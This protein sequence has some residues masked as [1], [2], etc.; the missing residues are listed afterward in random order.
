MYM[1]DD[2]TEKARMHMELWQDNLRKI[3]QEWRKRNRGDKYSVVKDE[4]S[5][6]GTDAGII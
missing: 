2:Q 1:K 6:P 5:Y 3:D 4:D